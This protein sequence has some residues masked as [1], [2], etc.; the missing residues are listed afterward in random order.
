MPFWLEKLIDAL[1]SPVE[2]WVRSVGN[3]LQGLSLAFILMFVLVTLL[4]TGNWGLSSNQ[5][6]GLMVVLFVL[7]GLTLLIVVVLALNKENPLF[8][9]YERSLRRGHGFGDESRLHSHDESEALAR[10]DVPGATSLPEAPDN[11]KPKGEL[12]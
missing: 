3:A 7:M 2:N 4:I 8:S 11:T 12:E 1:S 10:T 9:P 6:V 5:R